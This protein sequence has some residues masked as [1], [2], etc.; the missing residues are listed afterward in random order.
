MCPGALHKTLNNAINKHVGVFK[1]K[2]TRSCVQT[3]YI[4]L[5]YVIPSALYTIC[6]HVTHFYRL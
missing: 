6:G 5:D 2:K 3:L 1:Q 4:N